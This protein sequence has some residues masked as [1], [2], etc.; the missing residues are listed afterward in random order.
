LIDGNTGKPLMETTA[1]I[2]QPVPGESESS[3]D[4]AT[5]A[6]TPFNRGNKFAVLST[7]TEEIMDGDQFTVVRSRRAAQRARQQSS[8]SHSSSQQQ[9]QQS[10]RYLPRLLLVAAVYCQ[11]QKV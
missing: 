9:Q 7:V 4:W 2:L 8:P 6:S 5:V 10:Q 11:R 3:T 1:G